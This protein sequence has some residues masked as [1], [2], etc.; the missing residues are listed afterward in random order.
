MILLWALRRVMI[1]KWCKRGA[2]LSGG[3]KQRISIA[4]ALL[5]QPEILIF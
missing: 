5:M 4:R 1:L 3:Q 2:N